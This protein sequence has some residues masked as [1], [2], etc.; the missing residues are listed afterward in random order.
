[1][2][3]I[4]KL[5]LHSELELRNVHQIHNLPPPVHCALIHKSLIENEIETF[6]V[7]DE[8]ANH[9][10]ETRHSPWPKVSQFIESF[11]KGS[12]VFDVGCGNGKYLPLNDSIV[13]VRKKGVDHF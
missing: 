7:Y 4:E 12:I 1:M 5:M 10:S 3:N 13:K 2:E 6:Q 11:A 8:I 9:F